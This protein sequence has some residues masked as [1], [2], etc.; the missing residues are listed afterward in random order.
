MKTTNRG[1]GLI[2]F[3][4]RNGEGCSLQESSIATED[5]IWLGVH[6]PDV[7][8][9]LP[10]NGAPEGAPQKHWPPGDAWKEHTEAEVIAAMRP[11][12]EYWNIHSRMHLNREQVAMLLP[13]LQ[14]YVETGFLRKMEGS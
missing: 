4:D 2:E 8:T 11:G 3:N 9:F 1:F 12:A 7:K 14:R 13:H 6:D 10:R 5:C